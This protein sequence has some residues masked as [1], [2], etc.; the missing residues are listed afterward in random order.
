MTAFLDNV[1]LWRISSRFGVRVDYKKL[2]TDLGNGPLRF[3]TSQREE[4]KIRRRPFYHMLKTSGYS[5]HPI[6]C[7]ELGLY[8]SPDDCPV[9]PGL[10]Q[11]ILIDMLGAFQLGQQ[12]FTLVAGDSDYV[13]G[14][15][16]LVELRATV[17]VVFPEQYCSP[18][19]INAASSFRNLNMSSIG[20]EEGQQLRHD[21]RVEQCL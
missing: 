6:V 18:E 4:D 2:K 14:V 17:E 21:F 11:E 5:I 20:R 19:L 13:I 8:T 16:R 12:H 10:P 1:G 7:T 3:Y 15:S 9:A